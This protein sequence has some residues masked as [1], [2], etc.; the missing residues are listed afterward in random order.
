M[1]YEFSNV[2]DPAL[3]LESIPEIGVAPCFKPSTYP[4]P[5]GKHEEGQ[6]QKRGTFLIEGSKI[7]TRRQDESTGRNKLGLS[8]ETIIIENLS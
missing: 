4:N 8:L 2:P 5:Q 3:N 6:S 7:S 1:V